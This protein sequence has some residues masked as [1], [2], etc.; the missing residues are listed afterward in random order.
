M[1][2]PAS[3][4]FELGEITGSTKVLGIIAHPTHH[5]K[6]PPHINRIAR[7]R[8]VDAVMVPFDVAPKDLAGFAAAIRNVESFSGAIVTI[9]HKQAILALCDDVS[10]QAQAVGAANVIRRTPDGRLLGDQLDGTGFI[11]G[12]EANGI[13]VAGRKVFLA[14]AGG[15]ATAIGVALAAAGV[16][17]LTLHNRSPGKIRH[18]LDRIRNAYPQTRVEIGT[19]DPSGHDIVVNGTSLGMRP[20]DPLPFDV[21]KLAPS[22][23]VAEV[24]MEPEVT[25]AIS[26]ARNIGCKVHLG[27]HMLEQQVELMANF[28]GL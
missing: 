11:A 10:A 14:G 2:Q 19:D 17:L 12:L 21:R 1:S 24:V 16:S 7:A 25:A 18:L 8:G 28:M 23:T 13:E 27:R 9:P 5:V 3:Q 26:H 20:E 15:A 22:M 6:A 4:G